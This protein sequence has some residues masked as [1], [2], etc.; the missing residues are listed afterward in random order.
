MT[1]AKSITAARLRAAIGRIA[2][3]GTTAA[4]ETPQPGMAASRENAWLLAEGLPAG[5]I[6]EIEGAGWDAET[7]VAASSFPPPC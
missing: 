7:G 5:C 2:S 6:H 3:G 1:P 4:R